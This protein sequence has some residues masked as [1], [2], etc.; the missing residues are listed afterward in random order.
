MNSFNEAFQY[1]LVIATDSKNGFGSKGKLPWEIPLDLKYFKFVTSLDEGFK[2]NV[3]VMGRKTWD[4][5]PDN[6][7]PLRN[8]INIVF[9]Q[10]EIFIKR[11]T[12]TNNILENS[13]YAVRNMKE[14]EEVLEIL[15]RNETNWNKIFV[16]GGKQIIKLF[17]E[18]YPNCCRLIFHSLILKEYKEC[19]VFYEIPNKF[20]ILTQSEE[21]ECEKENT[22]FLFRILTSNEYNDNE[23]NSQFSLKLEKMYIKDFF[24]KYNI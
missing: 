13:F 9:T 7:K 1:N 17:E 3:V 4:S 14:F 8:R 23:S 20:N 11:N 15:K 5:I 6:F 12:S 10:D 18:T 24:E 16:I 21:I 22:K 2:K 19:D